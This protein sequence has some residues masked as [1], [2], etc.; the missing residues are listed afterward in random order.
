MWL[1]GRWFRRK[2][3]AHFLVVD[4]ILHHPVHRSGRRLARHP[5]MLHPCQGKWLHSAG[6][7]TP[8]GEPHGRRGRARGRLAS[9]FLDGGDHVVVPGCPR[10]PCRESAVGCGGSIN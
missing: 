5:G 9:P 1:P 4:V 7:G 6:G 3:H 10:R 2:K 8:P